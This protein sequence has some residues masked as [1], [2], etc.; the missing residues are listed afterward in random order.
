MSILLE[1]IVPGSLRLERGDRRDYQ[2]LQRFHYRQ[3]LPATF[4][5]VWRIRHQP[6]DDHAERIVAVAVLSWCVPCVKPRQRFFGITQQPY[7]EQIRFAN[8]N[9]RTLSRIIVH[10]Q[11]RGI[12]LAVRLVRCL[13][14]HCPTPWIETL[15]R[16]GAGHPLFER[17]G[18][19][20]ISDGYY[21]A[22]AGTDP[23][24]SPSIP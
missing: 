12:G 1:P 4:A 21:L 6:T 13:R 18:M 2:S 20:L 19:T 7:A 23:Q 5:D 22:R 11:F 3:A 16:M 15:A 24:S 10:P 8:A 14:E 9:L 17:A